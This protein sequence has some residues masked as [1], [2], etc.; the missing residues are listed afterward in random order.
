[1][2][3]L[4]PAFLLAARLA[5][6]VS[7]NFTDIEVSFN[8]TELSASNTASTVAT[9]DL[10]VG[11]CPNG[12]L[13]ITGLILDG[14]LFTIGDHH[15]QSFVEGLVTFAVDGEDSLSA[16][17]LFGS[18]TSSA[19]ATFFGYAEIL[20][21]LWADR[22]AT[23]FLGISIPLGGS[24]V[25]VD[26]GF[27]AFRTTSELFATP[28]YEE[29]EHLPEPGTFSLMAVAFVGVACAS[30]RYKRRHSH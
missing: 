23:T 24:L 17:I 28:M 2:S 4:L 20:S 3:K 25:V 27:A 6:P 18:L 7:L 11:V 14:P 19:D 10:P 1:M 21:P 16:K 13:T 9:C 26:E 29:P 30:R 22:F 15:S 8:G 5:S 12:N